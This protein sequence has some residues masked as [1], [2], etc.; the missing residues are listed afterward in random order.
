MI[1]KAQH[2][3]ARREK[4]ESPMDLGDLGKANV[5]NDQENKTYTEVHMWQDQ[6]R[7]LLKTVSLRVSLVN[8]MQQLNGRLDGQLES[9]MRKQHQLAKDIRQL[10]TIEHK[11]SNDG[12]VQFSSTCI[13]PDQ[14]GWAPLDALG[15]P[16][17][18][19]LGS[20]SS[21]RPES[22][23]TY[24]KVTEQPRAHPCLNNNR[25]AS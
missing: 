4:Q 2:Q 17:E 14:L 5:V 23:M 1:Q 6:N 18:W 20:F 22:F 10:Q 19:K 21:P 13:Q 3:K 7:V 24:A 11:V 12:K 25:T 15:K 8:L 9:C 16:G